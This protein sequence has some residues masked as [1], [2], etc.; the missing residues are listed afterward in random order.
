MTT[1]VPPRTW[2]EYTARRDEPAVRAWWAQQHA[3]SHRVGCSWRVVAS[4]LEAP[5]ARRDDNMLLFVA[6]CR[7]DADLVTHALARG[8]TNLNLGL[9]GACQHRREAMATRLIAL[10]ATHC[11]ACHWHASTTRPH[12]NFRERPR[13][14]LSTAGRRDLRRRVRFATPI[15]ECDNE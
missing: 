8:A 2:A 4:L 14:Q 5:A 15:A 13:A 9:R 6:A 1:F 3:E 7:G 11:S 10:G 12:V